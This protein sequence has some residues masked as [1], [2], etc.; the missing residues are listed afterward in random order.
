VLLIKPDGWIIVS[1]PKP[2]IAVEQNNPSLKKSIERFQGGAGTISG[3]SERT[4]R[5]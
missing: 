4:A 5:S 3:A 2:V 1:T